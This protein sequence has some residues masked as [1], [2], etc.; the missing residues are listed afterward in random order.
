V[1]FGPSLFAAAAR[2][3]FTVIESAFFGVTY[4]VTLVDG[5]EAFSFSVDS[6]NLAIEAASLSSI[7]CVKVDTGSRD[8]SRQN[9]CFIPRT[10]GP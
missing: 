10:F 9:L 1:H 5:R 4:S 6:L 7:V 2:F 3:V 8:W